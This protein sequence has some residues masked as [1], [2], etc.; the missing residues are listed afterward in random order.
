M[1]T[2]DLA[3]AVRSWVG[4]RAVLAYLSVAGDRACSVIRAQMVV[5]G[6]HG[7]PV[8]GGD[9]S[10]MEI[11]GFLPEDLL[12]EA[13]RAVPVAVDAVSRPL[14]PS[15]SGPPPDPGAFEPPL[16][17]HANV[18]SYD[19]GPHNTGRYDTGPHNTTT[20]S[21]PYPNDPR[22]GQRPDPRYAGPG[23]GD[24]RARDRGRTTQPAPDRYLPGSPST[25]QGAAVGDELAMSLDETLLLASLI[26][27]GR[28]DLL[29]AMLDGFGGVGNGVPPLLSD[30]ACRLR[31]A[32]EITVSSPRG[33]TARHGLWLLTASATLAV[34]GPRPRDHHQLHLDPVPPG[35]VRADVLSAIV[36]VCGG[37]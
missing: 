24:P 33:G 17:R 12:E 3:V 29:A 10:G 1:G 18:R 35:S 8:I 6:P 15:S 30:L 16:G 34:T 23:Y 21:Q 31:G 25:S 32:V 13:M 36:A 22:Y 20:G 2:A 26:R 27:E 5:S 19:T 37:H 28:D 9:R 11:S 14:P 7:N 4:A